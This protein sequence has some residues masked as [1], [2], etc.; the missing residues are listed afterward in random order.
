MK[1]NLLDISLAF[2]E[3]FLT[4]RLVHGMDENLFITFFSFGS[5]RGEIITFR[6]P[7]H[8]MDVVLQTTYHNADSR[9]VFRGGYGWECPREVFIAIRI[10]DLDINKLWN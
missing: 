8:L 7:G 6:M 2:L 4:F 3:W 1:H 9:K 10:M 5:Q